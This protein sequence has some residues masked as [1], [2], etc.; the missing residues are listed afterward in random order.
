MA[1]AHSVP[2][3]HRRTFG[4]ALDPEL[5]LVD[6]A[7]SDDVAPSQLANYVAGGRLCSALDL[8]PPL[9]DGWLVE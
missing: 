4:N 2:R 8:R 9:G 1:A 6:G 5:F 7:R 3:L